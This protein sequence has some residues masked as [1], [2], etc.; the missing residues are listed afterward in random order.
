M[1]QEQKTAKDEVNTKKH[2]PGLCQSG[3]KFPIV[4]FFSVL[5]KPFGIYD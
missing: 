3:A 2:V 1:L 4:F 5:L